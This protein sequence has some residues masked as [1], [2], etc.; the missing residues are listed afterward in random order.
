MFR[1]SKELSHRDVLLSTHN[2]CFGCEI[3]K[4]IFCYTLLSGGHKSMNE[5]GFRSD[6]TTGYGVSCPSASKNTVSP[7]FQWYDILSV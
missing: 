5:F 6:P 1:C 3:R 2:K 4:I 7:G